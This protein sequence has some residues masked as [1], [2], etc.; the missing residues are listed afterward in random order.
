MCRGL[1]R[2]RCVRLCPQSRCPQQAATNRTSRV[3][4]SPLP[5]CASPP[6]PCRTGGLGARDRAND[7]C[8]PPPV[9]Q[10]KRRC[11]SNQAGARR[12]QTIS[13]RNTKSVKRTRSRAAGALRRA[14]EIVFP[15]RIAELRAKATPVM[16]QR[17]LS[18]TLGISER[19]LRRI[20]RGSAVPDARLL[21][22]IAKALAVTAADLY[23]KRRDGH[24]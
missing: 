16:S 3:R 13:T 4:F 15:N 21:W 24:L 9:P 20:E 22:R 8:G 14:A 19:Q 6:Y 18:V 10:A 5:Q 1:N 17:S 12:W 2:T 23:L 7:P 11:L